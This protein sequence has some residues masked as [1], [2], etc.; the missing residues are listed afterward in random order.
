MSEGRNNEPQSPKRHIAAETG[1]SGALY[2]DSRRSA[3]LLK[4]ALASD[5]TMLPYLTLGIFAGIRPH[6]IMRLSWKDI[7]GQGILLKGHKAKTRQR[8]FV[9]V[10]ATLE[11]GFRLTGQIPPTNKRKRLEAIRE[12]AGVN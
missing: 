12:A 4:A 7:S 1:S 6:E 9:S 8:R 11:S 3:S 5:T 2:S 10:Q